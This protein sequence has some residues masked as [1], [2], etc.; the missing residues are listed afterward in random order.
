M[1][2]LAPGMLI[3]LG[4]VA[5][6]VILHFLNKTRTRRIPW[7]A[8]RFLRESLERNQRRMNIEDVILLLLRCLLFILLAF[9]FARPVLNALK[10]LPGGAGPFVAAFVIDDSLSMGQSNGVESR[11]DQARKAGLDKI[12]GLAPG[13]ECALFFVS[14]QVR[15]IIPQPTRDLALVRRNLETA[16]PGDRA[17]NLLPGIRAAVD[18]LKKTSGMQREIYVITDS[19]A[20][21]WG[22]LAQVLALRD[23]IKNEMTLHVVSVGGEGEP[24]LAVSGIRLDGAAL[25]ADQPIRCLV[26]VSN[27]GTSAA[28]G[29]RVALSIDAEAPS[30]EGMIENIP[31]GQ[32]RELQLLTRLKSPGF[33]T[34]TATI[35]PDRLPADNTRSTAVFVPA[36]MRA[37]I[38]EGASGNRRAER[39]GYFLSQALQPVRANQDYYLKAVTI[40]PAELSREQIKETNLII[41]AN[42]PR[43]DPE[44]SGLLRAFVE[45][46][47]GLMIFPGPAVDAAFYNSDPGFAGLMPAKLG[48]VVDASV[49]LQKSGYTHPVTA[50]W[51]DPAAGSLGSVSLNRYF[52]LELP[53]DKLTRVVVALAN[54]QPA[55][56]EKS[57]GKGKVVLFNST[58]NTLWG[59]LPLHPG[60]VPLLHRLAGYASSREQASLVLSPGAVFV[61]EVGIQYAGRE[62]SVQNLGGERRVAGVVE[63][64]EKV[65][66]IRFAGTDRAGAYQVFLSDEK[67]PSVSF[68]VQTNPPESNLTTLAANDLA[69]LQAGPDVVKAAGAPAPTTGS[70]PA[71]ELW[72]ILAVIALLVGLAETALAHRASL[73]H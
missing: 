59:N 58:A 48:A 61:H 18:S 65:G 7:A 60:F 9:V 35:P 53:A 6:P 70:G 33:H 10:S 30:A 34:L 43:L 22:E 45:A 51:N 57:L 2:F 66:L 54:G 49:S 40:S 23:E 15:K 8:M 44:T 19:Q 55:I 12:K 64:A 73:S 25:A 67:A 28:S 39:D 26:E 52:P 17:S 69:H 46:G 14:D 20:L 71:R 5:A 29:I 27:W 56:V 37:L 31:A 21:A 4:A 24:N 32:S 13:S 42:V 16:A 72:M 50:I 3:A 62:F 1:S 41:L 68:A 38:V 11:F 47:G 63:N 36:Q